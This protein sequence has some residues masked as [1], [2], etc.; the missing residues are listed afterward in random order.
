M[1]RLT[2]FKFPQEDYDRLE[3]EKNI[4][5]QKLEVAN[6]DATRTPMNIRGKNAAKKVLEKDIRLS[7]GEYLTRNHLLTEEDFTM[8]GLPIR[9][10]TRTPAPVALTY[11]GYSIDSG[12]IRRLIV[13][14]YD[15]VQGQGATK[16][17]AKPAG[18]HG[19]EIRWAISD[20]PIVDMSMLTNSS[21]DTRTP[22]TL[23]FEGHDRGKM[24]YFALRWE[25]TRGLKGPWSEIISAVIP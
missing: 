18:Q 16:T 21:F 9:K 3:Q 12:T 14:F 22:F 8:L 15:Q 1:S 13:H 4:Y 5:A 24:V 7:T 19:A 6:A 17:N 23:E 11:P 20:T 25:N 10:A 2:K